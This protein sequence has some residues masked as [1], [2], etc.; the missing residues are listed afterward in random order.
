MRVKYDSQG[1]GPVL[2]G[3]GFMGRCPSRWRFVAHFKWCH[4]YKRAQIVPPISFRDL[5]AL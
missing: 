5:D 2:L 3:R 4:A 1:Y